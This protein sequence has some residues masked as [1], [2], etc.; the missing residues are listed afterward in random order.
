MAYDRF[1]IQSLALELSDALVGQAIRWSACTASGLYLAAP[2]VAGAWFDVS[3]PGSLIVGGPPAGG[4][5]G[6]RLERFLN[7]SQVLAATADSLERAIHLRLAR[8]GE[9]GQAT[10]GIL[11]LEMVPSRWS[12]ALVSER[13]GRVLAL[14]PSTGQRG[15]LSEGEAYQP[16]GGRPRLVPGTHCQRQ[17][18]ERVAG[19]EGPAHRI[20]ARS[21][22]GADRHVAAEILHASGLKP[23]APGPISG[24]MQGLLWA[25]AQDLYATPVSQEAYV[26]SEA[27]GPDFSAL[28][29]GRRVRDLVRC[30]TVSAAVALWRTRAGAVAEGDFRRQRQIDKLAA[31]VALLERRNAALARDLSEAETAGDLERRGSVLLAHL[32]AVQPG[33]RQVSLPDTFDPSGRADVVIDL[34]PGVPPADQAARMLKTA[35][36]LRRRL[37]LVPPRQ[38]RIAA[39]LARLEDALQRL[40][41]GRDLSPQEE[42]D[43]MDELNDSPGRASQTGGRGPD[44]GG[45]AHPRR[46]R[47]SSGWLVLA[48]RNNT[49]NDILTHRMAA[50]EDLWFHASGY[51]GSHVVLRREGRREEPDGRTLEE[52]AAVAAYWSKGRTARKVPVIYTRAKHVSKPRGGAPGLAAVRREKTIM[53]AP[54]LLPME[55]QAPPPESSR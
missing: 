53:V 23:E 12:A 32:A 54:A 17:F 1:T 27:A 25:V 35:H 13:S 6:H 44:T 26:W 48:G 20:L 33:M 47:T 30:D 4:A 55:D 24:D 15:R 37:T 41:V 7:G 3:P 16:P 2:G 14:G 8:A 34:E 45:Q 22:A 52:V 19:E 31:R 11:I 43:W 40:R 50:Q 49:E 28:P 5:T 38:R 51:S 18:A 42:H 29:P 39:E 46:Y 9:E 36:R 21:L 10:Y